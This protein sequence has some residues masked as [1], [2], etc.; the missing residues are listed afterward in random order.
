MTTSKKAPDAGVDWYVLSPLHHGSR[1]Y[2][3]GDAVR[4]DD[5]VAAELQALGV[6]SRVA[7]FGDQA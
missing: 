1:V 7:P 3:P 6:V 4:L 2:E 5:A